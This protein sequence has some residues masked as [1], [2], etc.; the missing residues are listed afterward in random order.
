MSPPGVLLPAARVSAVRAACASLIA[1]VRR[2]LT[3]L[4]RRVI[5]VFLGLMRRYAA[6]GD[7]LL[8]DTPDLFREQFA[9]WARRS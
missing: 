5:L 7:P 8:Y 1:P 3:P 9:R 6:E 2:R 4:Q